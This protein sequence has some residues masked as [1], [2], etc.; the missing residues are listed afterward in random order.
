V[1]ARVQGCAIKICSSLKS[2]IKLVIVYRDVFT[3][4]QGEMSSA[5]DKG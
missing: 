4:L 2:A 3:R 5:I 1:L